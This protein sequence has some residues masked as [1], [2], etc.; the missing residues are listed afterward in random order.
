MYF[1]QFQ[2]RQGE[3][4]VEKCSR[5]KNC[6]TKEQHQS[7]N[8]HCFYKSALEKI[9][10]HDNTSL[11]VRNFIGE[12][13]EFQ[14]ESSNPKMPAEAPSVKT[15]EKSKNGDDNSCESKS[16]PILTRCKGCRKKW[17]NINDHLE[18]KPKCKEKHKK[19]S[20]LVDTDDES[21]HVSQKKR[22]LNEQSQQA[23]A[24][25]SEEKTCEACNVSKKRLIHHIEMKKSCKLFYGERLAPQIMRTNRLNLT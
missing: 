23:S 13:I 4:L 8:N 14:N 16:Q 10:L 3:M 18:L 11:K 6:N 17:E 25:E 7:C 24:M 19:Q 12:S 1:W 22:K 21:F 9:M 2:T 5:K 15:T 20:D